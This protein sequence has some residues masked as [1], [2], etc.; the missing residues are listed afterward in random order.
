MSPKYKIII[1]VVALAASYGAGRWGSPAK[2]VTQVKT[3]E[4]EKKQEQV[5]DDTHKDT[6]TVTTTKEIDK[7]DGTKEKETKV[8]QDVVDSS[9]Y[10]DTTQTKIDE[11]KVDTKEVTYDT[12][13]VTVSALATTNILSPQG[14]DYG[15]SV[16]KPILGP[17]T[18][19]VLG[20]ESGRIGFS[21][22]LTF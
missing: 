2:V 22:G 11:S 16:S 10:I 12:A 8:T 1:S 17:L 20:F 21:V 15:L 7:P 3:V 6:H 14:L 5:K 19:G 13:K 18:V 4:V 9:K